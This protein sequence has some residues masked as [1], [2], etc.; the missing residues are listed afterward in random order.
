MPTSL[1][2]SWITRSGLAPFPR[3]QGSCGIVPNGPA[4]LVISFNKH[5]SLQCKRVASTPTLTKWLLSS[6]CTL[7][8]TI[9]SSWS[10]FYGEDAT[11]FWVYFHK[12]I[13][14]PSSTLS[15]PPRPSAEF[16]SKMRKF[17]RSQA[18]Y[19]AAL[20]FLCCHMFDSSATSLTLSF[21]TAFMYFYSHYFL[22]LYSHEE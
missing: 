14:N 12:Q 16:S 10:N 18:E 13:H 7:P 8:W 11:T 4:G 6:N 15:W 5:H 19:L 17:L 20:A 3:C 9:K 1:Q 2:L 21:N 22:H